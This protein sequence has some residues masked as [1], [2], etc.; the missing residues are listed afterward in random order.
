VVGLAM[1]LIAGRRALIGLL[2]GGAALSI[3]CEWTM[4]GSIGTYLARLPQ[5]VEMMREGNHF[6]WHRHA[7]PGAFFHRLLADANFAA[8]LARAVAGAFALAVLV[9]IVRRRGPRDAL[10]AASIA[11]MPMM[12]PYFVDYDLM[13]LAVPLALVAP[14]ARSKALAGVAIAWYLGLYVATG[15][16]AATP[17]N[18]N[19]P[20]TAALAATL[21]AAALRPPRA[22]AASAHNSPPEVLHALR[23][24]A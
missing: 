3:A 9:A 15:L 24:A 22:A 21:L 23:P 16:A 2:I 1:V 6:P 19:V 4:P 13:L 20:T 18:L 7:T 5:N 8:W 11:A 12:M 10:I 14:H 17:V